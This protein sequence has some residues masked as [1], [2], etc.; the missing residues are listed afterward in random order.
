MS[1]VDDP[2]FDGLLSRD[3]SCCQNDGTPSHRQANLALD[4]SYELR[5]DHELDIELACVEEASVTS[6]DVNVYSVVGFRP[7]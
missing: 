6:H 4:E 1:Q 3:L 7:N 2:Q 5:H